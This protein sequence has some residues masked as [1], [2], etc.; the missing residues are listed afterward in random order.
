MIHDTDIVCRCGGRVRVEDYRG[1]G[2]TREFR[3]EAFCSRCKVCDPNGWPT[4][5][6]AK[7]EAA[8]Y[9]KPEV[10]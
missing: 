2:Y 4:L 10:A 6:T 5:A 9:F 7:A 1:K 3:F 8:V